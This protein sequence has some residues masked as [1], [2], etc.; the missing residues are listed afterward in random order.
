MKNK[1][2]QHASVI[3]QWRNSPVSEQICLFFSSWRGN[4]VPVI[5]PPSSPQ[6]LLISAFQF[7]PLC[8]GSVLTYFRLSLK[9]GRSRDEELLGSHFSA[10]SGFPKACECRFKEKNMPQDDVAVKIPAS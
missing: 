8:K 1:G 7:P 4:F 3:A 2:W 9:L 5:A 10:A 6:L